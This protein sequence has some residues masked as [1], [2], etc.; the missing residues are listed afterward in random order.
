MNRNARRRLWLGSSVVISLAVVVMVGRWLDWEGAYRRLATAEPG[1]LL[2]ALAFFLLNYWLRTWRIR[3]LLGAGSMPF[4][5][6]FG[7]TS[8]YGMFNYL[9]PAKSGEISYLYLVRRHLQVALPQGAATLVTARFFDFATLACFL[10]LAIFSFYDRLPTWMVGMSL[11]FCALVGTGGLLLVR[12]LQEDRGHR[13]RPQAGAGVEPKGR[14][15]LAASALLE[16]LRVIHRRRQY[17]RLCLVT[18]AIWCC[19]YA[20]FYAIV[21]SLGFHAD[22]LEL[23]VVSMFLVPLTLLPVQGLANLGTHEAAWTGALAVF[24][25]PVSASLGIAVTSHV[26]LFV[27]VV[28]VGALGALLLAASPLSVPGA[29]GNVS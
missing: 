16:G 14:I 3:W 9:M 28:A 20:N 19:I 6:L 11:L 5:R 13:S 12:V 26:V 29:S 24:G 4:L 1:W 21:A 7:V 17:T 8:L 2:A 22:W 18:I 10:P 25:Y 15:A 27:L 23:V